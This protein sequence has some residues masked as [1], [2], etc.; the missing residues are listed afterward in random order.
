M[1]RWLYLEPNEKTT[2]GA[3][4]RRILSAVVLGLG[5]SVLFSIGS[6][7]GK[8]LPSGETKSVAELLNPDGTLNLNTGFAGN[9]NVTGF[10]M[11][12]DND[13]KPRF[14]PDTRSAALAGSTG[15]PSDIYWDDRFGPAG[16][17]GEPISGYVRALAIDSL[18]A[19]YVGGNIRAA[20]GVPVRNIA[21]WDESG[22]SALGSLDWEAYI[23]DCVNSI[24]LHGND[25]YVGGY[26]TK[27]G[28]VEAEHVARWD[29]SCWSAVG[30]GLSGP[31]WAF[32]SDG[33]DLYA[34]G[35]FQKAGEVV[36]NNVAKW[37][38][39]T[40]SALGSGTNNTVY[41]LAKSGS[42]LYAGGNF[43]TA[44]G[45]TINR[46]AK[47]D[48][49]SWSALGSGIEYTAEIRALAASGS[50]LYAGGFFSS[51]NGVAARNVAKWDGTSWSALGNGIGLP[52]RSLLIVGED[53]YAGSDFDTD[54]GDSIAKWDGISWTPLG[55]GTRGGVMAIAAHETDV[56]V[57]G[58]FGQA[59]GLKLGGVGR[60]DGAC[61]SAMGGAAQ[62][63][64]RAVAAN[65]SH[66]YA[67]E[68]STGKIARWDGRYWTYLEAEMDNLISALV[69][70]ENTLYAGGSFTTAGGIEVNGV[71]SWDGTT[72]SALGAGAGPDGYVS[73]LVISG[74]NVYAAGKFTYLD[75]S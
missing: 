55:T 44:G 70:S 64:I 71:A 3:K 67:A 65:K 58:Y 68:S 54:Y 47:W 61:W 14:D 18:G 22:W 51:I 9:L 5:L 6:V 37:D 2:R 13:G 39:T 28:G 8:D 41:A 16:I 35:T 24:V 27:A 33:D 29:G 66:M 40:W 4:M 34:G 52:V 43:W 30:T 15:D 57:G 7:F 17:V 75:D 32:V 25:V 49:I 26:F 53:L 73:D 31:V 11:V 69:V 63:E 1:L 48:G 60:W 74:S 56:Y 10:S 20:G 23:P 12:T 38:G 50:C 46:I 45:V 19:V 42:D 21:K 62:D 59:D 36:V 72:W